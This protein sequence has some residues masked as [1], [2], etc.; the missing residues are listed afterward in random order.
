MT[1][2]RIIMLTVAAVALATPALA[3]QMPA[4]NMAPQ[5]KHMTSEE[6]EKQ[7]EIDRAYR[8]AI[9]KLPDQQ[10]N[11]DPWGNVRNIDQSAQK[12]APKAGPKSAAKPARPKNADVTTQ[13]VR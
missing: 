6:I 8:D 9:S 10:G 1:P 12:P 11:K 7:K 5:E 3:Q 2:A 4:I 13:A